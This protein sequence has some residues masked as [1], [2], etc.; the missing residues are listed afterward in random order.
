MSNF[1]IERPASAL[2]RPTIGTILRG[3]SDCVPD[4]YGFT[5]IIAGD[6][7]WIE[8][9]VELTQAQFAEMMTPHDDPTTSEE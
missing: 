2:N 5:G 1:L 6:L 8:G 4:T 7:L 9:A 3:M